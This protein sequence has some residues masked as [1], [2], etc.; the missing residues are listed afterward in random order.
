MSD[1]DYTPINESIRP[2]ASYYNN[3]DWSYYKY[4]STEAIAYDS[5]A[6]K[7]TLR[8]TS[9][10]PELFTVGCSTEGVSVIEND[11]GSIFLIVSGVSGTPTITID[12][13]LIPVVSG[14]TFV[15]KTKEIEIDDFSILCQEFPGEDKIENVAGLL[16]AGWYKDA[17][18]KVPYDGKYDKNLTKLYGKYV[19]YIDFFIVDSD[20]GEC[21]TPAVDGYMAEYP[22]VTAKEGYEF[23]G[24]TFNF[25]LVPAEAAN[26][27]IPYY[28]MLTAGVR[29]TAVFSEEPIAYEVTSMVDGEVYKTSTENY[30]DILYN[31]P[32]DV[33]SFQYW[34]VD[35]KKVSRLSVVRDNMTFVASTESYIV[36][37]KNEDGSILLTESV[38]KGNVPEY[39][40]STPVKEGTESVRYVF[41]GWSPELVAVTGDSIYTATY[42]EVHYYSVT[43]MDEDGKTVLK[44]ERIEEGTIPSYGTEMPVKDMTAEYV[45]VFDKW[46]PEVGAVTKDTVYTA[47]YK[48]VEKRAYPVT[49][50]D[51]DGTVLYSI[52]AVEFG[53]VPSYEGPN[54]YKAGS[55]R[56]KYQ[57]AGWSPAVV[58]VTGEATYT[59]TYGA[60]ALHTVTWVNYDQTVLYSVNQIEEG[61]IATYGGPTPTKTG[62]HYTYEFTSWSPTVGADNGD[63]TYTA[64]FKDIP[65][66]YP[67]VFTVDGK[68]YSDESADYGSAIVLP[69][70][71]T[72]NEM[73]F[74]EWSGYVRGMTVTGADSFEAVFKAG[75]VSTDGGQTIKDYTNDDGDAVRVVTDDNTG[76]T[77][78]TTTKVEETKTETSE[79]SK[80]T[81]TKVT[82][83]VDGNFLGTT[84]TIT[85]KETAG[86]TVT[87]RTQETQKDE[88]G[89]TTQVIKDTTMTT[90]TGK[91]TAKETID[92]A[93]NS[94]V[95]ADTSVSTKSDRGVVK[96]E[97]SVITGAINDLNKVTEDITAGASK[98]LTIKLESDNTD[99]S[100]AT[101]TLSQSAL[102]KVSDAGAKLE[103]TA[104]VGNIT[105]DSNVAK[106]LATNENKGEVSLSIRVAD[107]SSMTAQQLDVVRNATVLELSAFVG[108]SSIHELGGTVTIT[109]PYVLKTNE[110]ADN[111]KV[112]YITDEG[113]YYLADSVTYSALNGGSITFTT[114]HF[115]MFAISTEADLG[116]VATPI[117]AY[118]VAISMLACAVL[119]TV[120][121][122]RAKFKGQ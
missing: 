71:P 50:K 31:A 47:I 12:I 62:E 84:E 8:I 16:F 115:S 96:V 103:M 101:T 61:A 77:S 110:N 86:T 102:D 28:E 39:K 52:D 26:S 114:T 21:S 24:W 82:S 15:M 46:T 13:D 30:G 121:A 63:V 54:P 74:V 113:R 95:T 60:I 68:V 76:V 37:W 116:S 105:L 90:D 73:V 108:D 75:T 27:K 43:W 85:E 7:L 49:W 56:V 40:G 89:N 98:D 70:E 79:V 119:V 91:S 17:D 11:D 48:V 59:A 67:V 111:I 1:Y 20:K 97:D 104:G 5:S 18:Y 80:T 34:M 55:D 41:A 120:V 107:K 122:T 9:D 72:K 81:S 118:F 78:T 4:F 112:W 36:T 65:N 23:V 38:G 66:K 22:Q 69:A 42:S 53:T 117:G 19:P 3:G 58:A 44:S 109:V 57:F 29:L 88:N 99:L 94:S 10:Y 14:M 45:Y 32:A 87:E 106:T 83:D 6:G 33:E 64:Q 100:S 35:G 93:G 25:M 2:M 92:R 51:E